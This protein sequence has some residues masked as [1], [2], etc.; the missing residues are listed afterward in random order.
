MG[1]GIG[2]I[3]DIPDVATLVARME[4]EYQAARDK[5]LRSYEGA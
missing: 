5:L 2:S 4:A 3:A 1:Q